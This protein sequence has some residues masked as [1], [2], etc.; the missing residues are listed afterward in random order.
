M[1]IEIGAAVILI[2]LVLITWDSFS[3]MKDPENLP[4]GPSIVKLL[5]FV[6]S[7]KQLPH[8][9]LAMIAKHY[10]SVYRIKIGSRNIIVVSSKTAAKESLFEK[11]Q[12]FSGRPVL[13]ILEYAM[14]NG[15]NLPLADNG[16]VWKLQRKC[17]HTALRMI[18]DWRG[19]LEKNITREFQYFSERVERLKNSPVDLTDDFNLFTL[20][21]MSELVFG[22]RFAHD[23]PD[24]PRINQ[25][26][27]R[28][29]RF[30]ATREPLLLACPWLPSIPLTKLR[31]EAKD[32]SCFPSYLT[33]KQIQD[34]RNT[35]DRE[36]IRDFTDALITT[37]RDAKEKGS[38]A[39]KCL[40]DDHLMLTI[41]DVVLNGLDGMSAI[42]RWFVAYLLKYPHVQ[43]KIH[44]EIDD[45]VG[46]DRLPSLE[47]LD[48]MPYLKAT[49]LETLRHSS[50][51]PLL[52][53]HNATAD[54][55][56]QGYNIPK[57]SMVLFNVSAIHNDPQTWKNPAEFLPSRFLDA[58]GQFV[59]PRD[60]SFLLFGAGPRACIG[61]T[62]SQTIMLL[63]L[64][65]L[66]H[67]FKLTN[68][69]DS[70]P[71]ALEAEV[72]ISLTSNIKPYSVCINHRESC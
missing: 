2:P 14:P 32:I 66:Y 24:V 71:V 28:A 13:K 17:T 21:A 10:G 61:E 56:L 39:A 15:M 63:F 22:S 49:L 47:D 29:V 25:F 1:I 11:G 65:Q 72:E 59:R 68:P 37:F 54:T 69:P 64:S 20:N 51:V 67:Q 36:N 46:R 62:L 43:E 34:H 19:K 16:P 53:P 30:F 33:A 6:T 9:L 4:P 18:H 50:V 52:I 27:S 41:V 55:T 26:V 58:E 38:E 8:V 3:R 5:Q 45:V 40:T 7:L 57:D 60:G 35:L 12:E 42:L 44:Q 31:K 48:K 70:P 23:D